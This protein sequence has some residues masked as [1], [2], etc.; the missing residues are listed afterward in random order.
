MT[1]EPLREKT[2]LLTYAPNE[3]SNRSEESDLGLHCSMHSFI[4]RKGHNLSKEVLY[5]NY[6]QP[7]C[8]EFLKWTH[9][10]LNQDMPTKHKGF[11]SKI[12]NSTADSVDSDKTARYERVIWIYSVCI[13]M[14]F[15]I[16]M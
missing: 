11:K 16:Y 15:C 12:K 7:F 13:G 3:N 9:P 5:R 10:F 8:P 4:I 2:Y 1:F 6:F 14:G